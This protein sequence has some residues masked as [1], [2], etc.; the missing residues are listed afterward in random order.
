[1]KIKSNVALNYS[2]G[3][4]GIKTGIIE[5]AINPVKNPDTQTV[6]VTITDYAE[7]DPSD[8]AYAMSMGGKLYLTQSSENFTYDEYDAKL[9]EIQAEKL[10]EETGSALEDMLVQDYLLDKV[11]AGL[12]YNSLAEN[13][14]K[15]AI[16]TPPT[17]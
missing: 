10:Y 3:R 9:A 8:P 16:P 4:A 2:S 6:L 15:V 5:I 12:W 13:W 11:V 1:M 14:V 17:A 7:L